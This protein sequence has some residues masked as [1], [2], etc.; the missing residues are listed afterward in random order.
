MTTGVL[1]VG[2]DAAEPDLVEHFAGNGTMP[3]MARLLERSVTVPLAS[4]PELPGAMWP[5]M[6]TG[7]IGARSGIYFPPAQI[8]RG[9]AAQGRMTPDYLDSD[10]WFWTVASRAGRQVASIDMVHAATTECDAFEIVE[11]GS[12]DRMISPTDCSPPEALAELEARHGEYPV[13]SCDAF[14]RCE[15]GRYR[16]LVDLLQTGADRKAA[17]ASDVLGRQHWDLASVV[18]TETHCACHQLWHFHDPAHRQHPRRID[19]DLADSVAS[20]YG[21]VDAGLARVLE[22]AGPDTDVVVAAIKGAESDVGGPQLVSDVL[23]ALKMTRPR[24]WKGRVWDEVPARVKGQLGRIPLS[25]RE[26]LGIGREPGVVGIDGE[27]RA[28]RNDQAGAVRIHIAG[29]DPGGTIASGDGANRV[30]DLIERTF[31]SLTHVPT[32]RPAVLDVVRT[33]ERYGPAAHPDL[34]DLLIVFNNEVGVIETVTSPIVGRI[35]RPYHRIR[36][37]NHTGNARAWISADRVSEAST[38]E[39]KVAD[40]TASVLALAGVEAPPDYDGTAKGIIDE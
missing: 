28:L 7:K 19:D 34:P 15:T 11:W 35:R 31:R 18:F 25:T 33:Q 37:G 23:A 5:E 30:L 38:D 22:A 12:H 27:A 14:H 4:A 2:L 6:A 24:G 20:I 36:T 1:F 3:T 9:S 13:H 26:R 17:L 16:Q 10:S 40:V 39:R 32:G 8:I 21:R 29:R